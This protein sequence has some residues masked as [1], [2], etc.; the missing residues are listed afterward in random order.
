MPNVTFQDR[1]V[2]TDRVA[3]ILLEEEPLLRLLLPWADMQHV[4]S[5]SIPGALTKGDLDI[6]IRVPKERFVK[7]R[8]RLL[9]IYEPDQQENW[10]TTFASFKDLNK[11][12]PLGV[13]LTIMGSKD[14]LFVTFR[15][16]LRSK[17]ELLAEYN[18]LKTSCEGQ[19]A[20]VYLEK[21]GVFFE[22]HL[23]SLL[24]FHSAWNESK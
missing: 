2:F 17:P 8:E 10:S 18:A 9:S 22:K 12:L 6:V 5:T 24:S 7:S 3:Q 23:A 19:P 13:Q 21:K 14:D 4:G 11:S 20:E 16:A 15:D 1:S